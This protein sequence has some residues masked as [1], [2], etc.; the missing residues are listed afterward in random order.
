MNYSQE[1]WKRKKFDDLLSRF[2]NAVCNQNTIERWIKRC[3]LPFFE[4]GH[5]GI[6]KN[7]R[8]M[9]LIS[10]V[11]KVYIAPSLNRI[12]PEIGKIL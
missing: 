10:V 1:T 7:Y 9:T 4:K 3:I 2:C 6:A 11:A 12:V 5:L 8:G